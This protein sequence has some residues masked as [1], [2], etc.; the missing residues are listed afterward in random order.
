MSKLLMSNIDFV[1]VFIP[2]KTTPSGISSYSYDTQEYRTELKFWFEELKL[3]WEW[4]EITLKNYKEKVQYAKELGMK[5][6][7]QVF[8]FCDGSELDSYP[9]ISVIRELEKANVSFTGAD[10]YF[11]DITTSKTYIKEILQKNNIPTAPFV[12]IIKPELDIK[13]A[14]IEIGYPFI[15]KPDI[16]AS[17]FGI[18]LKSVIYDYESGI[19]MVN[20]L[21]EEQKQNQGL[22]CSGV[23]AE[24][25]IIGEEYSVLVVGDYRYPDK[26]KIYKPIQRV[27]NKSLPENERFLSFHRHCYMDNIDY[28][29]LELE[30]LPEN[31]KF[32]I[33]EL[34]QSNIE[35]DLMDI[36]KRAYCVLK[37]TGYAR[38]DFRYHKAQEQLY[39]LE[40]NSNCGI[41]G[42]LESTVGNI[43]HLSNLSIFDLV[44][45]ILSYNE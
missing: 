23:F 33:C 19:K 15:L 8:N 45:S 9:G 37:G 24:T 29:K 34:V 38:I 26:L 7:V 21:L 32:Y 12:K 14:E 1:L 3:K 22:H 44:K 39:V 5:Y 13:K 4:I 11:F 35:N 25:F 6:N 17:S 42:E 43:L 41:S 36:S 40:V 30:P 10:S 31:D 2:Y 20:K 27:F 18:Y 28:V 16:S